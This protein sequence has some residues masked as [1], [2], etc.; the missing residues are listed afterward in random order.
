MG[1]GGGGGG[2]YVCSSSDFQNLSFRVSKRKLCHCWYVLLLYLRF[3]CCH[4]FNPSLCRLSPFLLSYVTISRP[5]CLLEF[6]PNRASNWDSSNVRECDS[7]SQDDFCTLKSRR[8]KNNDDCICE[9]IYSLVRSKKLR[10][11]SLVRPTPSALIPKAINHAKLL[12]WF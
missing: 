11:S 3:C 4:S 5:Y 7:Q 2:G 10:N 9:Q 12:Q 6:Y 8:S 1:G